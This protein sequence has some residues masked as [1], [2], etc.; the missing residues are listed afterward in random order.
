MKVSEREHNFQLLGESLDRFKRSQF[1]GH[2][3]RSDPNEEFDLKFMPADILEILYPN[4]RPHGEMGI[5]MDG[6][7]I[8]KLDAVTRK[9]EKVKGLDALQVKSLRML[10]PR[11]YHNRVD[12]EGNA[13]DDAGN[14]L[15]SGHTTLSRLDLGLP[16]AVRV[17]FRSEM[18]EII[19]TISKELD[20]LNFS[21]QNPA[22][23]TPD[24]VEIVI[25]P[26]G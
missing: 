1:S 18:R 4:I 15:I 17:F 25:T 10:D 14:I 13:T 23:K 26:S 5:R 2:V 19:F 8:A 16:S 11:I 20:L 6:N 22:S 3:K 12:I 24:R 21:F 7:E 9:W